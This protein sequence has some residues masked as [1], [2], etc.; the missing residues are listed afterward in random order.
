MRTTAKN[1]QTLSDIAVKEYGD[2]MAV[3]Q[4]ASE[5]NLPVTAEFIAGE[6]VECP[7]AEYNLKVKEYL[8][9]KS[10]EPATAPGQE[11]GVSPRLHTEHF[12]QE[13]I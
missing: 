12:T 5:N 3:V 13:F 2:I 1:R 8:E 10:A 6:Q 11:D 7:E 4:I 9:F